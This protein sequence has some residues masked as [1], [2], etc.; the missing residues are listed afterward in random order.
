MEFIF[1]TTII[2]IILAGYWSLVVFPKQRDYK[3]HVEYVKTLEVGDEVITYGGLIGEIVALED[4]Y[5]TARLRIADG[6]EVRIITAALRQH[7][8]ADEVA[9]N[10]RMAEGIK[11]EQLQK[12]I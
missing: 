1:W 4:D 12:E 5:G 2:I 10:I 3:K 9:R 8:D 6:V 7:F 11:N